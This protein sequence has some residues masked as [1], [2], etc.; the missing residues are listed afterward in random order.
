MKISIYIKK[1][2]LLASVGIMQASLHAQVP[3]T[4]LQG[5]SPIKIGAAISASLLRNNANYRNLARREY[6][7]LTPENAMKFGVI[8]PAENTYSWTDADTIVNFALQT[9]KRIHG[10]TLIWHNNVPT[11]LANFVGDSTAWENI[12]KTHIQ[13]VVGHYKD[14]LTSWDVVNEAVNDDGTMRNTIWRQHLGPNYIERAFM[15]AHQADPNAL[16]FYNDYNHE[17]SSNSFAKLY[18]ILNLLDTLIAHGIPIHGAGMQMHINKNTNTVNIA[19]AIDSLVNTGLLVHIS[20]L[21]I[22]VNPESNQ[23]LTYTTTVAAQQFAKFKYVA[24]KIRSIPT[25]QIYGI[26]TWNV[27]DG[28]SWIPTTYT[29]PDFPLL[30]SASYQKKYSFQGIKDGLTNQWPFAIANGESLEGTYT[31]LGTNGTAIATDFNGNAMDFDDDNS[32]VQNIGFNFRFNGSDYTTF[33]LNSNG[34]IKLG[35]AAPFAT[36]YYYASNNANTNSVITTNDIDVL[37]PYNHNLVASTVAPTAYRL[38][39]TGSVGSR[40]CTVQFKNV[41]EPY[42]YS[43]MSF[44]IK[45]YETTNIIEFVYDTW[46]ANP[47]KT[48][49]STTAAVGIRG[50]TTAHSLNVSKGSAVAWGSA[51][52]PSAVYTFRV[53]DYSSAGPQFNSRN[54]VLP[55]SGKTFRFTPTVNSLPLKLLSFVAID[56][57]TEVI[58]EWKTSNEISTKNF[59]IQRSSDGLHFT[60][61][62]TVFASGSNQ[63]TENNYRYQDISAATLTNKIYYRLRQ[64]DQDGKSIYSGVIVLNRKQSSALLNVTNPF[65]NQ[66]TFQLNAWQDGTAIIRIMKVSGEVLVNKNVTVTSGSNSLKLNETA[67]LPAG[68]Y[69]LNVVK[70]NETFTQ[71]IIK[72]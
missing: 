33:V 71:K 7:S 50:G 63:S 17:S 25:A 38:L 37:Y 45:M 9:N 69:L 22:A 23:S 8:H 35:N 31:D 47:T 70:G 53:G 43:N 27:T 21:D 18:T 56:N 68:T 32:A 41:A 5:F 67:T 61:I 28:D 57:K 4:T 19:R 59:E 40:V 65:T 54:D 24:E 49:A 42:Q 26:T 52:N 44:Q 48:A 12:M 15:Y 72:L 10:H 66:L 11:W 14:V 64:N 16:L 29:R 3:D 51:L 1:A 58:L 6:N 2:F 30:F 36:N 13:T 34:Y 60:S 39:T 55:T 62:A 46:T 20:E